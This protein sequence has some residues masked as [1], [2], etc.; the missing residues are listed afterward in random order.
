MNRHIHFAMRTIDTR[1]VSTEPE[2]AE[3]IAAAQ[4]RIAAMLESRQ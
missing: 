4:A 3:R 2:V 1:D